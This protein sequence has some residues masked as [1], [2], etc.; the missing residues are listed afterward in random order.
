MTQLDSRREEHEEGDQDRH[1]QQHRQTATHRTRTGTTIQLHRRLLTLQRLLLTRIL[2]VDL[3]HLRTQH[4][5]LRRRDI[6]LVG[7]RE[8][9]QLHDHRQ[10]ENQQTVVG[11]ETTEEVEQRN[12]KVLIHPTEDTPS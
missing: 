7:Q 1:L 8:E 10:Q 4:T 11:D 3:L 6:R 2:G 12:D 5:H 9:N